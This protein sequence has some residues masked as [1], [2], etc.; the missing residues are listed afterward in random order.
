MSNV[1]RYEFMGSWVL[2]WFLFITGIGMPFAILYLLDGTLRLQTD[3]DDPEKF[4][5]A[6]R[7][8]K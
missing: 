1:V 4:V 3:V 2:F 8:A 5:E 6:Y 7:R